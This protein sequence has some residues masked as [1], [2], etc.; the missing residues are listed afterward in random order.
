MK[1]A[2][3]T[4][5]N[6]LELS[7]IEK[8]SANRNEAVI[9]VIYGGVCGSDITVYSGQ[10]PTAVAPVV[11]CHEIL[12]RIDQLPQ[13]YDGDL[14]V[15]DRVL[16]DPV[17]SCGE[18]FACK[19]GI[20][21]VCENLK[22]MGIHINGGFAQ[23]AKAPLDRLVRVDDEMS[24]QIAALGEPFAVAYHVN[25]RAGTQKND[26][27]LMIGAGAIGIITAAVARKL[28]ARVTVSEIKKERL[29]LAA[30]LD[31]ET[32]ATSSVDG[33]DEL[34][35]LAGKAGFDIVFDAS[36]SKAGTLMLPDLCRPGGKLV[37][38]G[39][40]SMPHEFVIGKVSF[41]EL[42][43]VGSR[44]YSHEDFVSGV[45]MLQ[46]LSASYDFTRIISDILP[47]DHVPQAIR[48]MQEGKNLGKILVW[49]NDEPDL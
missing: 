41:K 30:S 46:A 39:L 32:V 38:L 42:T 15:G 17:V 2:L 6:N 9:K 45:Q 3:L 27:V 40:S 43:L 10:H 29:A 47:L 48:M 33:R 1:A 26:R 35:G 19:S 36:G 12:G 16:A 5:W 37:S 44:L 11:L 13:D 8:P 20:G 18:C 14:H 4:S 22:L 7:E 28:G 21:N 31:F 25:R 34:R 23:Y 24:D 49:C